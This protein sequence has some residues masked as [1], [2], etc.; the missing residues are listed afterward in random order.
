MLKRKVAFLYRKEGFIY[1]EVK[2]ATL[3]S[4]L[5]S[6]DRREIYKLIKW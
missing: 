1:W 3:L 2:M 4:P 6:S 5:I